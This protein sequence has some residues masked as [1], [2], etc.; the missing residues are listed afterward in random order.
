[1]DCAGLRATYVEAMMDDPSTRLEDFA[2]R[3]AGGAFGPVTPEVLRG[4]LESVH[5]DIVAGIQTRASSTPGLEHDVEDRIEA[6]REEMED[7]I[8]RLCGR[9]A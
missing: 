7:L 1:M 5:R 8:A 6:K 4:F 2:T 9:R 3:A